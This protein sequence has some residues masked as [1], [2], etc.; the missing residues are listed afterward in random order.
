MKLIFKSV[1]KGS[2]LAGFFAAVGC[3]LLMHNPARAQDANTPV[4][5]KIRWTTSVPGDFSFSKKWDY[6]SGIELRPNGKPGCADGGFCPERAYGMMDENGE[7]LPDSLAAFYAFADTAHRHHTIASEAW[8]YE[9]A[10]TDYITVFGDE[11][12]WLQGVTDVNE[13]THS[14]LRITLAGDTCFAA[15]E[16]TSIGPGGQRLYVASGGTFVADRALLEQSILKASFDFTFFHPENP[17]QKMFW[18]G[19]IYAPI[20]FGE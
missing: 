10:G 15:I 16:L 18:K 9:W 3:V 11:Q 20:S 7:I 17:A 2:R 5:I 14:A 4:L 8:C 1:A 6:P 19:R 12:D 13:A